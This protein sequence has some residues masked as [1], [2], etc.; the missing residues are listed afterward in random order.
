MQP[1]SLTGRKAPL[2]EMLTDLSPAS[3]EDDQDLRFQT[4]GAVTASIRRELARILDTRL[5]WPEERDE[6]LAP[7]DAGL[8]QP[9]SREVT[10]LRYGVPDLTHLCIR[11]HAE[12]R[13]I[14]RLLVEAIRNFEPRI[15]EPT[16]TIALQA[17]GDAV[18]VEVGGNVRLGRSMEPVLF[19]VASG[20]RV[21]GTLKHNMM[22]AAKRGAE[23]N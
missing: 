19:T 14:E 18:H 10:V 2:L 1:K 16:V 7:D 23:G 9:V 22:E 3:G 13:Q 17:A 20:L 15:E 6:G 11:N 5:P 21:G 12:R 4:S 8:G